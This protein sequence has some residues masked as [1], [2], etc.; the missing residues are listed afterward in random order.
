QIAERQ[1]REA[2]ELKERQ[3]KFEEAQRERNRAA[4]PKKLPTLRRET[5]PTNSPSWLR[6]MNERHA[7]IGN[8]GGKC[9]I[10]EWAASIVFPGTMEMQHQSLT[11]F[12]ERYL[13]RYIND[14]SGNR[15]PVAPMWLNHSDHRYYDGIAFE[16]NEPEVIV[17]ED[18][19]R[20][21]N[22]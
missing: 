22:L 14:A 18:G 20:F 9:V 6:E 4:E 7:M 16:P 3:R 12:R 13:G 21:M 5:L 19:R 10:I 2:E 17:K 8:Y 15:D 11:S 1:Q